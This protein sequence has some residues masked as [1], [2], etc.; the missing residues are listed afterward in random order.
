M[1]D[2]C[3]KLNHI[4]NLINHH[5]ERISLMMS[6]TVSITTGSNTR[7]APPTVDPLKMFEGDSTNPK[8]HFQAC[9]RALEPVVGSVAARVFPQ[10][11]ASRNSATSILPPSKHTGLPSP[12][13]VLQIAR[14]HLFERVDAVASY[15]HRL[16]LTVSLRHLYVSPRK[17]A[18]VEDYSHR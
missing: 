17:S 6:L 18:G 15:L 1:E 2:R 16:S 4:L 7:L 10:H 3:C 5:H 14:R 12:S 8:E 13:V 9:R 11:N